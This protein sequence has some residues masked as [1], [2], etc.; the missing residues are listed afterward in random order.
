MKVAFIARSSLYSVKGGDTIQIVNTAKYLQQLNVHVD[1]KLADEKI[2]Y[3]EYDLLHFFNLIRPADILPHISK[4]KIPFVVTPLLIDYTEYDKA[5]RQGFSGKLFRLLSAAKTEYVK[6]IARWLKGQQKLKSYSYLLRGHNKSIKNIIKNAKLF[7]PNSEMEYKYMEQL[8][9]LSPSYTVIPNGIDNN[10][11]LQSINN[12][13]EKNN[14]MVLCVARIEGLKNQLNL[15][16]ALNNTIYELFIIGD[17]S[18]NQ[19]AYY[20][21]CKKLAAKNIHFINHLPQ[22]ELIQYYQKAKVH[23]LPSW[24]ETCG[25]STLEA[26]AMGCNVVVTDKGYTSE[27]FTEHAFYCDPESPSSIFEKIDIASNTASSKKLREKIFSDYTWQNA[28]SK[29]F[30][31][32]KK[33]IPIT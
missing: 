21:E 11:F 30:N 10:L 14:R 12:D 31:A 22:E 16:K 28:A 17:A 8:Y 4:A 15:I 29:T 7:L 6:T 32:Y 23:V 5:Y 9:A 18:I 24:F 19:T 2:D 13:Y 20:K 25:L 1:I 3:D 33:I 26:A 27:Y